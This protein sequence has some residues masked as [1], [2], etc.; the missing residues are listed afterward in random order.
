MF[1]KNITSIAMGARNSTIRQVSSLQAKSVFTAHFARFRVNTAQ[2]ILGPEAFQPSTM[3]LSSLRIQNSLPEEKLAR[4]NDTFNGFKEDLWEKGGSFFEAQT[5]DFKLADT[6]IQD[7]RLVIE[8]KTGGFSSGGIGSKFKFKGDFD[9]QVDCQVD[10]TKDADDMDQ[11]LVFNVI[12]PTEGLKDEEIV[13][14]QI[15]VV[16]SRGKPAGLF[17][18]SLTKGEIK[19]NRGK[20]ID[21]FRGSLRLVKFGQSLYAFYRN[22]GA[23]AW[24]SFG[25]FPFDARETGISLQVRNIE[26]RKAGSIGAKNP[27]TASFDNFRVNAAQEIIE[28]EI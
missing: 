25:A 26:L 22:E 7:G 27:F 9:I 2:E 5:E 15:G 14:G 24:K 17:S 3:E 11:I 21:R 19:N 13:S 6:R 10:F 16:K 1:D 23:P 8:T 28:S 12:D 20:K 18:N 4:Y